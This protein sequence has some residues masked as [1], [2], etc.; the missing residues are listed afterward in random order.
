MV[1][2]K[3]KELVSECIN[4]L[5]ATIKD[6]IKIIEEK[7]NQLKIKQINFEELEEKIRK[8]QGIE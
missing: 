7:N 1:L 6:K 8:I 5:S 3:L 4:N 2:I